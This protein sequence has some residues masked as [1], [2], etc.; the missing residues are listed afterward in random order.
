MD[1]LADGNAGE[2]DRHLLAVMGNMKELG[3]TFDDFDA[4]AASA[5]C[6][7][8]NR[9]T[10]W[11]NAPN[12]KQPTHP[13]RA[14]V[15]LAA[16]HYG[17]KPAST[18]AGE[19]RTWYSIGE[20]YGQRI[21]VTHIYADYDVSPRAGWWHYLDEENRWIPLSEK[22]TRMRD[23]LTQNRFA[24]AHE[25][26]LQGHD[27]AAGNLGSLGFE[28]KKGYA[29]GGAGSG[30][31][32]AGIRLACVAPAPEPKDGHIGVK[33]GVVDLRTGALVPHGPEH[34]IRAVAAGGFYPHL[35]G[36]LWDVLELHL[37]QVFAP[38]VMV[39]Y[40]RIAALGVTGRAPD[41]RGLCFML[42]GSRSGKGGA[43]RLLGGDNGAF[44]SLAMQISADWLQSLKH[45]IDATSTGILETNPAF[46]CFSE[47]G[48][49]S[50]V[51]INKLLQITGGDPMHGRKAYG[52]IRHG[53]S[54]ALTILTAVDLPQM[55]AHAGIIGRLCV[56]P[57]KGHNFADSGDGKAKDGITQKVRD[58][59]VTLS[60]L[61]ASEVYQDGYRAPTGPEHTRQ[62]VRKQMDPVTDFLNDLDDTWEGRP[63][64][65][66]LSKYHN[67]MNDYGVTGSAFGKCCNGQQNQKWAN[68]KATTGINRHKHVLT[69]NPGYNPGTA[70]TDVDVVAFKTKLLGIAEHVGYQGD[71]PFESAA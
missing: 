69:A 14:I 27:A 10:R 51:V 44:G 41:L 39:D 11:N 17:H 28:A 23:A 8:E 47:V 33:N 59:V 56:L 30:E 6:T 61:A 36:E 37:I 65:Q 24:L 57:T 48:A 38:S 2:D 26:K 68:K 32:W 25:L 18:P 45:D 66:A 62:V 42:G 31:M 3:C 63:T 43:Q 55:A 58:A 71:D 19:I 40:I 7:C 15:N 9:R 20:W 46:L 52:E 35:A 13:G 12:G 50:K 1:A 22:S 21:A 5:G 64:A 16:K 53:Q 60:C 49:G 4:W 29:Y 70:A 67:A 54:N 34:G